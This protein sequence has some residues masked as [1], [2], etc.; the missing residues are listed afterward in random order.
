MPANYTKQ[1]DVTK[2][3]FRFGLT[4]TRCFP[5]HSDALSAE[6]FVRIE[7]CKCGG[8]AA[9]RVFMTGRYARRQLYV[10][11]NLT[12]ARAA[13]RAV[14]LAN[15]HVDAAKTYYTAQSSPRAMLSFVVNRAIA[16]GA[17]IVT[18]IKA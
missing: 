15:E 3:G 18:E 17:E 16:G 4:Q 1:G 9:Y 14:N 6:C 8:R 11:F 5:K 12:H 2:Q 7:T 10:G 13:Y